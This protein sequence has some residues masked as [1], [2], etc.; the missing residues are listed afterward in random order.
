MSM[1]DLLVN[2]LRG[3]IAHGTVVKNNDNSI[4]M[5]LTEEDVKEII[6]RSAMNTRTP[7]PVPVN[8]LE[9]LISVRID[10]GRIEVKIKVI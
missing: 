3:R 8:I 10:K 9:N 5:I 7:T 6:L 2:Q 1:I 4:S